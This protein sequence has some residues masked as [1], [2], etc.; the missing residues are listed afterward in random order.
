MKNRIVNAVQKGLAISLSICLAAGMAWVP[1]GQQGMDAFAAEERRSDQEEEGIR[2]ASPEGLAS[3]EF[4]GDESGRFLY[5]VRYRD[6]TVVEESAL[7]FILKQGEEEKE[8]R[9]GFSVIGIQ[10][11]IPVDTSWENPFGDQKT[12][13]ERYRETTISLQAEDGLRVDIICRAYDEGV[14]FRYSFPQ[15]EDRGE[16]QIMQELTYFHLDD[17]A[18]AYVHKVRNQTEVT[19]IPVAELKAE[20]AGYFRPMTIIGEGYAMT[21]TEANQ[22]DYTRVHFTAEEGS[23]PGTLRTVFNGYSDNVDLVEANRVNEVTADVTEKSFETSWRTFVLGEN[24]GELVERHYL[25]Q[26]LN[27]ECALEDTSWITPGMAVRSG[28]TTEKAKMAIDFAVARQIEYVH[29]DAGWYGPEGNMSSDPWKCIEG[30]DLDEIS[31][32]ADQFGIRLMVYLNYRHLE[33]EYQEGRLD[34]LFQMYKE[35][36]GIDGIKF[37]F[38]PVGSQSST[39]MVYEWVKIAAK[40]QMVVDIHDEMLTTGY[41]RTYPNLL[42]YEAIHGDEEN[43]TPK[44]DLGYLFTRM[45]AGQADHTWCF[46]RSDRNTTKAFRIAGSLVYYSPLVFPYWYDDGVLGSIEDP[47]VGMWDGMPTTWDESHMLESKIEEYATVARRSGEEW[48]L[49]GISA[50]DRELTLTLDMLDKGETYR[51]DIYMNSPEDEKKVA[52][53]HYLTDAEDTLRYRMKGNYGCS[54]R[55]TK[56]GEEDLENLEAYSEAMA[57]AGQLAKRI[58]A[59]EEVTESNLEEIRIQ[60]EEMRGIYE[61]MDEG[62]KL[63]VW[64]LGKLEEAEKEIYRLENCPVEMIY[65]NGQELEGFQ[66]EQTEYE[67]TLLGGEALPYVSSSIYRESRIVS[68]SQAEGIPGTASLTVKNAFT[69]KNYQIHFTIPSEAAELYASDLTD[70]T[71]DGRKEFKKDTDRSGGILTLYNEAGERETFEKGIGTHAVTSISYP[72]GGKG[73]TRFQGVCGVSAN[74][75]NTEN[76]VRFRIYKNEKKEENLLFDSQDMTQKT[77]YQIIDVDVAGADTVI[78][79]AGDG[80]DGISND[81]ANWCDARFIVGEIFTTPVDLFIEKAMSFVDQIED[82]ANREK[83]EKAIAEAEKAKN[84]EGE[85]LTYQKVYDAAVTLRDVLLEVKS[86][87]ALDLYSLIEKAGAREESD[88]EEELFRTFSQALTDAR[89]LS[90]NADA[91]LLELTEAAERLDRALEMLDREDI[92]EAAEKAREAKEAAEKAQSLAEA[93][94][95]EAREAADQ[96]EKAREAAETAREESLTAEKKAQEAQEAAKAAAAAAENAKNAS[97]ANEE[98]ARDAQEKAEI[99]RQAAAAAKE[100]A[101]KARDQAQQAEAQAKESEENS[102]TAMEA[103]KTAA[104]N[105]KDAETAAQNAQKAAETARDDAKAAAAEAQ[106]A[107]DE[108]VNAA[109]EAQAAKDTAAAARTGAEG[110]REAAQTAREAA[111]A[112]NKSAEAQAKEAKAAKDV[113]E[114]AAKAAEAAR[115]AAEEARR[116]A[117]AAQRAAEETLNKAREEA[118]KRMEEANLALQ[119]AELLKT[120]MEGLLEKASFTSIRAGFRSV[121]QSGKRSIKVAWK[122]AAG[123]D[124]YE[125]QYSGDRKFKKGKTKLVL[126]KS[127]GSVK[128]RKLKRGKK[129]YIRMRAWKEIQGET[130]YTKYSRVKTCRSSF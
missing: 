92:R 41:D 128:L 1:R 67:I 101:Q 125:I 59:M 77:P 115:N 21:I 122:K 88:Y 6:K 118:R 127:A 32:Y 105:A 64:N 48:Y 112:A 99:A 120:Q 2:V 14:A 27:P 73:I 98:A 25:V 47:A 5:K 26:N 86:Y 43:P 82:E 100:Q 29:F 95:E 58:Q 70:Y 104:K 109:K 103:A 66:P 129:Y 80:Q 79:E 10:E 90:Q 87:Q 102:R 15:D 123:A 61:S 33:N 50:S 74:N 18:T 57:G 71:L 53:L 42:T 68:S 55:L 124:G 108:A 60:A 114:A 96:A 17:Q 107:L 78:L 20:E 106:K 13:P 69:E 94:E 91:S 34:Q 31:A 84:P 7:G 8:Y 75:G 51:A 93:S 63:G 35:T 54:V 36:W 28:L 62:Q 19:K 40:N 83:L 97:E 16:F 110:A 113:A 3:A 130:V 46:S 116:K 39:K 45:V 52:I 38:V 119:K 111:E 44:D 11:S 126:R 85:E 89:M 121:K 22:V 72:I 81:H 4:F 65:V 56:A 12:V 9:D 30:F 23:E 49:A 76:K 117:E 37:G 24:E